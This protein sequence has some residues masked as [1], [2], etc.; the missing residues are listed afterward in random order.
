MIFEQLLLMMLLLLLSSCHAIMEYELQEILLLAMSRS[1]DDVSAC[2][3]LFC[4]SGIVMP[5][6]GKPSVIDVPKFT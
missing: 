4:G 5:S 1:H 6:F 2:S 3:V